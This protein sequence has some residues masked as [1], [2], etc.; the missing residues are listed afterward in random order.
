MGAVLVF[1][2]R[3][4]DNDSICSAVAYAHLKNLTDAGNVYVPA[5]LGPVPAETA[6]VFERFGVALPEE[7]GHVHTRV[8]DVMTAEVVSV[9][10]DTNML[11]AGRLMREHD[12][13]ALPVVEDGVVR[14]LVDQRILAD[15]YV[16]ETSV[17]GFAE[18]PVT[19][20]Q[21]AA[22]VDGEVLAGDAERVLDGNVLIGA[23]EPETMRGHIR[24]GDTLLVGDRVR[25]QPMALEAGTACLVV[26]GG[27]R[28]GAEV[29]ERAAATGAA[30]VATPHD[31]Y[32]AARRINLSR[33]VAQVMDRGVLMVEPDMLLV[34]AAEDLLSGPQREAVV[35][36]SDGCLKGV[37]TR[38]NVAR[39]LR[40][41]VVLVD[42]NELSQSAPGVDEAQVVE[43]VDHHRVGDVQT[44]AP[45]LFLNMPVGS[46]AT[47]VA[48]RYRELGIAP[49]P[50]MAGVMLSAVL[51]DTV[52]L[53][54]PTATPAD[55]EIAM[56]LAGIA[57]VDAL[58]FGMDMFRARSATEVFS[59]EGAVSADLKEYH[60]RDERVAVAQVETVDAAALL[61]A[62]RDDLLAEM[63][64]LRA[65]R[66][67]TLLLLMVTD[68]VREGT[69]VVAA[70]RTR[71]AERAL[72]VSLADGS[73][74][75]PG[76]LSRKKQVAAR[77]L[78]AAG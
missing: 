59:A 39:G 77:L 12:V 25:T 52:L 3:N 8:R 32:A 17:T 69:E 45:I 41:R 35:V 16:G 55:S 6:W 54:S 33:T 51:S 11:E 34:E 30:V 46:T 40:R 71:L 48:S 67:Y 36:D 23:M 61:G 47:I 7:V 4:P 38:T 73:A 50:A 21:L 18:R 58:E 49:P 26:T 75:L 53:K 66:G 57:G 20:G 76:V 15:L 37:L 60:V 2:H 24:P 14:G 74:W 68:V 13:R 22:A 27:F 31:T 43:I 65:A 44:S 63:E 62:H 29:L 64:R 56:W 10:P 28:P 72:G 1:G 70:G 5:R 9:G 19:V 42:H 78:E